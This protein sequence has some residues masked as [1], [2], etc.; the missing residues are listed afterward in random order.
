MKCHLL[1]KG[2]AALLSSKSVQ[3]KGEL[4]ANPM[5]YECILCLDALRLGKAGTAP[6]NKKL[7]FLTRPG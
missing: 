1:E 7:T 4:Y 5:R 2:H 6:L 3:I